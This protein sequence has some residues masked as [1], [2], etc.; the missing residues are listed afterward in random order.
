MPAFTENEIR[1]GMEGNICFNQNFEEKQRKLICLVITK[2]IYKNRVD[3]STLKNLLCSLC[4]QARSKIDACCENVLVIPAVA[5]HV[6]SEDHIVKNVRLERKT[7]Y[8]CEFSDVYVNNEKI[9]KKV[10]QN[11]CENAK[12]HLG[13]WFRP[14]IFAL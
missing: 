13:Y 3:R 7:F 12:N 2:L 6:L 1:Y 10:Q 8:S 5:C 9:I 4:N 14:N 11:Q